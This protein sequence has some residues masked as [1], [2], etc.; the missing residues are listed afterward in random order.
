MSYTSFAYFVFI[1][2]ALVPYYL[3]PRKA[4]WLVLLVFSYV[5]Y[6]LAGPK[7]MLFILCTTLSTWLAGNLVDRIES[8]EGKRK[9]KQF[10]QRLL[11]TACLLL[12]FGV[13]Y[14][15]K[16][17]N[18]SIDAAN[19]ILGTTFAHFEWVLPLGISFYTFQS[20]GYLIDVY[21]KRIQPEKNL[22]RYALFV[23]FFPQILQGPIGR[24]SRLGVQFE[25]E[26]DFSLL[27]I[28]HGLQRML[29][30][31]FMKFVIADNAGV[32]VNQISN[33]YTSY[34]GAMLLFSVLAYSFQLYGDFAGGMD[35]V[36]GTAELFGITLDEN[37]K[38][39]FFAVSITDFWHR[40]HITLGIW[41]KDYV[42]YPLSLTKT[43]MK[44]G[45][46]ARKK[47]GRRTGTVVPVAAANIIV[48]L[49]VG[50][51]HGA[52][53]KFLVYGLYNGVLISLETL[54]EPWNKKILQKWKINATSRLWHLF[55]II[56]TFVLVNIS[57]YWDFPINM[58]QSNYMLRHTITDFRL[59]SY[60][61]GTLQTLGMGR[62][63]YPALMFGIS[64]LLMKSIREEQGNDVRSDL[65]QK[66]LPVRWL[67]YFGILFAVLILGKYSYGGFIYA[68]F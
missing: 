1:S 10:K 2:V 17:L 25:K 27:Q 61:D 65:D 30:G 9:D 29:W 49:I 51:W 35:V 23:S 32:I 43:F 60:V 47:F 64:V 37:F 62:I 22:F 21:W 55:Q 14:L 36:I 48:F 67:V 42:F 24:Y 41:M 20:V 12:N 53:L 38:R 33:N 7:L 5:F 13:L 66:S 58:K 3:L 44:L 34:D 50:I 19:T 11:I 8:S 56:R 39:P 68:Q 59:Q 46:N 26:H 57:W 28:Q 15:F 63:G 54:L 45:K 31:Y 4:Q 16:Y 52:G 40:W 18:V 6:F